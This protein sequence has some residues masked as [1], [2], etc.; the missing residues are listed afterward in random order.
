MT[1]FSSNTN[2]SL[3]LGHNNYSIKTVGHKCHPPGC[4]VKKPLRLVK[5]SPCWVKSAYFLTNLGIVSSPNNVSGS[6]YGPNMIQSIHQP[7][8][9]KTL[10][11]ESHA[12][13]LHSLF[14]L[15]AYTNNDNGAHEPSTVRK[16][17]GTFSEIVKRVIEESSSFLHPCAQ[18][19]FNH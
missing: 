1:F 2:I 11:K 3:W 18:L 19:Y 10:K 17:W 8:N 14:L 6:T 16:G 13:S 9:Y 5:K 12:V 15:Y 7:A 4:W